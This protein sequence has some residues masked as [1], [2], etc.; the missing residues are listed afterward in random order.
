MA[1]GSLQS[2]HDLPVDIQQDVEAV[3]QARML[4]KLPWAGMQLNATYLQLHQLQEGLIVEGNQLPALDEIARCTFTAC[5]Q[6]DIIAS[7]HN[8]RSYSQ[9]H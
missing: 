7:A 5:M 4:R 3:K 6:V 1:A 9:V 2:R 8:L